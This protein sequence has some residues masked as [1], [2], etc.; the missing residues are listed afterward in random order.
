MNKKFILLAAVVL[1]L[2]AADLNSTRSLA[3][4]VTEAAYPV[5][6]GVVFALLLNAPLKFFEKT[7][8]SSPKLNK[9]R[10]PLSLALTL[11]LFAG[12]AAAV[13][14]LALPELKESFSKLEEG[15]KSFTEGDALIFG[16]SVDG[17]LSKLVAEG[18]KFLSEKLPDIA[19]IAVNTLKEALYLFIGAALGVMML[20]SK[21]S[22]AGSL[23]AIVDR[24]FDES[25]AAL[26]KGALRAA[27][28]KFSRFL[29]GQAVEALI[30]GVACYLAFLAFKVPYALLV[31]VVVA[32]GN[33]VPMLGGYI[34]GAAGFL[35]VLTVSPGKALVFLAIVVVLQQIEQVT[36]YP[37]I[38]GK[39]VGLKSFYVLLAVVVGGG[40]F[41]FW[42]L[43]LGVPV[44]AFVYNLASVVLRRKPKEI[45]NSE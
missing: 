19:E 13:A 29:A 26:V 23:Y 37:A 3:Q 24:M 8:L 4:A 1:I 17:V 40:L 20:A 42:G 10:R 30:F 36:T 12:T 22:L 15:L 6:V 45:K 41:G 16:N 33:L 25:K 9:F 21:E 18:E 44:A 32:V 35:I 31:A 5:F 38:V 28:D 34:G 7:L 39:Y 2:F 27:A 11:V 43:V 14:Y